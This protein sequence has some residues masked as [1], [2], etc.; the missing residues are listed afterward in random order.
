[1]KRLSTIL[2]LA[3]Y[4]TI[5]S[6]SVTITPASRT[7]AKEG[8]AGSI[9]TS[10]SG[11]WSA[12]VDVDWITLHN[13]SG[14]AGVSCVYIVNAN[15][16]ADTRT[17]IITIDG[18]THTVTQTGYAA[19]IAPT[20]REVPQEG[21]NGSIDV[22]VDAGISWTAASNADWITL[23]ILAGRGPGT[24]GYTIAPYSGDPR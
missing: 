14:D 3:L 18:S 9:L 23:D 11:T 5:A 15:F 2:A 8:S 6:A 19:S 21:G 17:G 10:G 1:M 4:A 20:S 13:A 24:V 7:F 16:T 12:T 22:T